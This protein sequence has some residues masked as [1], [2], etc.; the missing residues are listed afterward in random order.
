MFAK[1][2]LNWFGIAGLLLAAGMLSMVFDP[3]E[4]GFGV[5]TMYIAPPLLVTGFA[6]VVPGLAGK[7]LTLI[8]M[9][10]MRKQPLKTLVAV[11]IFLVSL[12]VYVITLEPTASLWDCAEFIAS[13][14]KLQVP[15][16]PGNPLLLLF[17]RMFS[18]L[19]LGDVEAV[20]MFINAMSAV[21]S[22]L[23]VMIVY[24][25]ILHLAR[26]SNA[27]QNGWTTVMC[28]A[29]G[30]LSLAFSDTFWF[31]AVEAETYAASSFFFFLILALILKG[32]S[33]Q[34]LARNRIQVLI[35][36]IGGLS[37]C[38][39]PM[40]VLAIP[41]LPVI[42]YLQDRKLTFVAFLVA[43]A[44]GIS[45]V[46]LINRIIA[47]GVFQ[48]TFSLDK[49]L[50]NNFNLPF[51]SGVILLSLL[52]AWTTHKALKRL[53]AHKTHIYSLLFLLAGFLPYLMLFIR[54]SHN[55]PI[56]EA[57]PENLQLIKAYMNREGYPTRPLLY[58]PY[59]D[60]EVVAVASRTPVYHK[61]SDSYRLS[62]YI[63]EY[64]YEPGRQTIFPRIYSS[65][66][67]HIISYRRW[68]GLKEGESP[69]FT[70]N[71]LFL[72]R[73]QLGHM[74]LRYLMF[75]FSG[76][77]SDEQ[78]SAWL[79]PWSP[80]N[81]DPTYG[82]VAH[83]Q[84][85]MIPL[86]LG[87]MGLFFQIKCDLR[88]FMG[89]ALAFLLAGA[90]LAI[91]L[92]STPNEPRERDY[93]YVGS[94][95]VFAIWIGLGLCAITHIAP[96]LKF[97]AYV[98]LG[99][100]VLMAV[101]NWNDHDRSQ[102]TFQVDN[103]RNILSSCAPDSILF[104]GGDND[105]FP[106]W[107]VQEVEGFR[108]DVRVVVLSY[109]NTDWYINQ[110]RKQ[111]YESRPFRLQL[112]EDDYRQYGRNDAI[113]VRDQ[114]KT[115][116]DAAKFLSLLH[117]RHPALRVETMDGDFYHSLPSKQLLLPALA[118]TNTSKP[119]YVTANVTG[120]Y[121]YKNALAILDVFLN[122]PE[123]PIYF[124]FT[125][126]QQTGLKIEPHLV[127]E[128]ALFRLAPGKSES[129]DT[130]LS[131]QNLVKNADY[132][133]LLDDQ[134]YFSYEDHELR[135]IHPLRQLCNALAYS[136]IEN[137]END[138]AAEALNMSLKYFYRDRFKPSVTSLQT[139]NLMMRVGMIA[140][141][142]KL[143][144]HLYAY[145]D[146]RIKHGNND[147]GEI[148]LREFAGEMLSELKDAHSDR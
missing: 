75:N 16:T 112:N 95:G 17:G 90:L 53:S 27:S 119:A 98:S 28:A 121:L 31:S 50:V 74:Y 61:S 15:H 10:S 65:D 44:T 49:L 1:N 46:L 38:I 73:Y 122:N 58:G 36:Y 76:R 7:E 141:A 131:Y 102:R 81:D 26:R 137:G 133:N 78:N 60:A 130:E 135:I 67:D 41:V 48:A 114:L 20:A 120:Q 108:T 59:F 126:M 42:W 103:A 110:L 97:I 86:A 109:L 113:F 6:C 39:H 47:I 115:A 71:I 111:Y 2:D 140:E 51:Y 105:T 24:L 91:Y 19:S 125:S 45:I 146:Y 8:T 87:L 145:Q 104:T 23:T 68:T 32:V 64:E 40:C 127:Q 89:I 5:L 11:G 80:S 129:I 33:F 72:L 70:H 54:S 37:F 147:Q 22:S 12:I 62:G 57:N 84:Y 9:S 100:P 63:P 118:Q 148:E 18:M 107:Y 96:R 92:N 35:F 66:A 101:E 144:Q 21:F 136:L 4:N 34:G 139:A 30:S 132:E 3:A 106:L 82:S 77:D 14:Y 69:G 138:K 99:V 93:I 123:R 85:W 29:A 43:L 79:L 55:P 134:V 56:D 52:L 88:G 142:Q 128:G 124:N 94:Y 143:V 25:I 117:E 83:N 116:V 13:A